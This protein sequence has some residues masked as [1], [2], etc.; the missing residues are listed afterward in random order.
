MEQ[1]IRLKA[2]TAVLIFS[3]GIFSC[4]GPN[5]SKEIQTAYQDLPKELD[6]NIHVKP[7]LS[8]KCYACHGPDKANQKAGLRL[9]IPETALAELPESPGKWAI[10]PKKLQQ[11]EVFHRITTTDPNSQ[12]PPPEFK[13]ILTDYEKAVLIK[14]MKQGAEYK[15]HWA[16][17]KPQPHPIPQIKDMDSAKNPIDHFIIS[18]LEQNGWSHSPEADKA[19]LLRRLSLDLT[20]LPPTLKEIEAFL[21]DPSKA[22]Y[23]KQVDRLLASVHYGEKM[24]TDWM[25][26]ARFSDTYG[27][28]VDRYRDMSPWRDWVIHSFNNN[29]PYDEFL[30]WQL[31]GDL[32]PNATR[33]QIMATG[34][35]RLHPQNMEDGII[36]EEFRVENVSDR[37]AVLGDGLMGLTLSCAK[38]HDHKYDPIS[39]KEYY[40]FPFVRILFQ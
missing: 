21:S 7:I 9:D 2:S 33:E 28:Q 13:V 18:Q 5:L 22:A 3:V 39:Q 23:E 35:N 31:A 10:V 1:R 26:V 34:F 36:D 16:F 15:P 17:I 8:D 19:M 25:D 30:T 20:G 12:M 32:L 6:F 37:V 14:W 27:Y 40:E 11:S 29:R 4:G 24:A 38:C